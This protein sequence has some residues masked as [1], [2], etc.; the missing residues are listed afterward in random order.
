MHK[1]LTINR[2]AIMVKV[3]HGGFMTS[4]Q[5]LGRKGF[6]EYGIPV[7][8]AMDQ[9]SAHRANTVLGNSVSEAVM[10]F[11]LVGPT[12]AFQTS[13][14]ICL[15]GAPFEAFLNNS[16]KIKHNTP[17]QIHKGDVVSIKNTRQGVFGYLG[18]QGGWNTE[19]VFE[20]KSMYK[21]ITL[22]A[23]IEK[24]MELEFHNK[25]KVCTTDYKDNNY[26]TIFN[27]NSSLDVY[28]GPE[29]ELLTSEQQSKLNSEVFTLSNKC[30]R[31]AYQCKTLLD[32]ELPSIITSL[33]QPGTVQLT[34]KGELIIL[35]RD[36][37][38]TGGYPRILQ[39]SERAINKLSQKTPGSEFRFKFLN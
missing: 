37:Q 25:T 28:K 15:T 38:T 1:S 9:C 2:C 29:F 35:M 31:M 11:A 14:T 21:E 4:I 16:E 18:I 32:N 24:E 34:P 12:L 6:Q 27:N 22:C 39:L 8:G 26:E 20:S 19:I 13:A 23:S 36:A 3:L 7:S 5:D 17:V 30:N 10:E 33:V